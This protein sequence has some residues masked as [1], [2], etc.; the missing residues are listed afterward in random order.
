MEKLIYLNNLYDI[1][2]VLL[3][4]KQQTYFEEYYF[5]NLSYGEISEK[6]NISR[7]ASFKQLKIIEEKLLD[8]EEKLKIFY[9]KEKLNAIIDNIDDGTLKSELENL[10]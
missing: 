5:N 6:Y 4:K 10:F 2:G 8:L 1:Y 9:K 7:N 3:T